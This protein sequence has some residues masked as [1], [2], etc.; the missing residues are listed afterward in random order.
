MSGT[1]ERLSVRP[2]EREREMLT[3]HNCTYLEQKEEKKI[4]NSLAAI[5]G[6]AKC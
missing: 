1:V 2:D 3:I 4:I 5:D 6:E